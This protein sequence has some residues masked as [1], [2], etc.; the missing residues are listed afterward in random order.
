MSLKGDLSK[1]EPSFGKRTVALGRNADAYQIIQKVQGN[2]KSA[3]IFNTNGHIAQI[4]FNG[5]DDREL[6]Y[7]IL[8]YL[9]QKFKKMSISNIP[10]TENELINELLNAGFKILVNQYE[11]LIEL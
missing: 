9:S 3:A 4:M 2:R 7:D 1:Y 5:K 11:I 6:L 8:S 10:I